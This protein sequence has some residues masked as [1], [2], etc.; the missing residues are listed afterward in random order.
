MAVAIPAVDAQAAP[1]VDAQAA[2]VVDAQAAP[3]VDGRG[4]VVLVRA[5]GNLPVEPE[6]AGIG[7][8]AGS[9]PSVTTGAGIRGCGRKSHKSQRL[10]AVGGQLPRILLS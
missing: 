7:R 4:V 2:R 3:V 9:A 8:S 5:Q 10:F 1:A 6:A